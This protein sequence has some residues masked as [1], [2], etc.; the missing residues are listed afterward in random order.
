MRATSI[1]RRVLGALSA[2]TE[3]VAT[4]RRPGGAATGTGPRGSRRRRD[5]VPESGT[6]G[7]GASGTVTSAPNA[8][9][10]GV[11]EPDPGSARSPYP[12]DHRGPVRPTYAPDLDGAA[13]PGEVVWTWVPYEE[14]HTRG[15]DRPVLVI[16]RDG[17]WLLALILSTRDPDGRPPRHRE[18]WLDLGTGAWDPRGRPSEVRL[19]RVLRVDPHAVRRE[20]AVLDRCRF[21]AVV[22]AMG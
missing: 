7:W 13:D 19:D 9:E 4:R 12:G 18:R 21:D 17:S 14:D 6:R 3:D 8:P 5:G 22:R 2:R 20:G 11:R 15:K 16:G 10:P 1:L